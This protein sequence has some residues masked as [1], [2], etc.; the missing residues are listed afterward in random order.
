MVRPEHRPDA[1]SRI[2]H[3]VAA[4]Q[5]RILLRLLQGRQPDDRR[6]P[7]RGATERGNEL[8]RSFPRAAREVPTPRGD[9]KPTA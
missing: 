5:I 1:R 4:S 2:E 9:G 7:A 6:W 8:H 3:S